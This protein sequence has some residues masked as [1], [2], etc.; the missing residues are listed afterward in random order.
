MKIVN[1]MKGVGEWFMGSW[2]RTLALS[3]SCVAIVA[4]VELIDGYTAGDGW[5]LALYAA[6]CGL[7]VAIVATTKPVKKEDNDAR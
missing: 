6:F 7:M 3:G 1:A 4:T 2:R 5:F